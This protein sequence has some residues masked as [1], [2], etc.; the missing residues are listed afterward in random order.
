LFIKRGA[1]ADFQSEDHHVTDGASSAQVAHDFARHPEK[2]VMGKF[3]V[4]SASDANYFPLLKYWFTCTRSLQEL[5]QFDIGILSI[6]ARCRQSAADAVAL[7]LA[8][9][10]RRAHFG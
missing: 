9:L 8:A 2:R 1:H 5:A 10:A 4:V 6:C 3:V 7:T